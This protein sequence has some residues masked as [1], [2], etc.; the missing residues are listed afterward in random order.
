MSYRIKM[1]AEVA[2][3]LA[4]LRQADPDAEDGPSGLVDPGPPGRPAKAR[5][6]EAIPRSRTQYERDLGCA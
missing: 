3:W 5:D 6:T 1:A 4:K 2:G